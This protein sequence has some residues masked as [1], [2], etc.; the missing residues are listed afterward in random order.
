MRVI[1]AAVLV[2]FFALPASAAE[3]YV[4]QD[5]VTKKCAVVSERP[6]GSTTIIIGNIVYTS[7]TEAEA[8]L[9]TAMACMPQ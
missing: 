5:T 7:R 2:I 4:V 8:G 3:Y 9:R 1:L 6:T